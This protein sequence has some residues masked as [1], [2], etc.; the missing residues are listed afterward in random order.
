MT[1]NNTVN[2][3]GHKN[4]DTDSICSAIAYT[5]LKNQ[6]DD[7]NVYV[8]SRAGK[9]SP[10]TRFVLDKFNI[11]AP[12]L[13]EDVRARVRDMEI[14]ALKGI[15]ESDSMKKAWEY[16]HEM[17]AVSL[18][19]ITE[20]NKLSGLL[21]M[22]DITQSYM[23]VYD[24]KIIGEAKTP[25]KNIIETINGKMVV[26]DEKDSVCGGKVLIGAQNPDVMRR[27]IEKGDIV[28]VGNRSESQLCAIEAGADCIIISGGTHATDSIKMIAEKSSVKIIESDFDT[29]TL[30]RLMNQSI[31][32]GHFMN[33]GT[34]TTFSTD[35]FLDD[36][37]DVMSEK[38][39][40][41]F[42]V[43]DEKG[44]YAGM[45][46]R[47]NLLTAKKR[48]LILVDHNEKSQAVSGFET[49]EI[50][51][52][53]DH[54]RIGNIETSSPIFFRNMA[55]GCT[56]TILYGMFLENGIDIPQNIAG[57][58][59]S[60]ILS[61]TLAFRSPTCTAADRTRAT[62]LREIAHIDNIDDYASEMFEAGSNLS[63]ATPDEIFFMDF[64]KFASNSVDFGVGQISSMSKEGL[65]AAKD[66]L[67]PEMDR[68]LS[69]QNC[70]MMFFM[71]TNI[72]TE[73]SEIIFCG[74]DAL[75]T[76]KL[77]FVDTRSKADEESFEC[78]GV[79][80]RKKQMIPRLMNAI[81]QL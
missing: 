56:A 43:I 69:E 76:M 46:S 19:V 36:V 40:R 58:L 25:Y 1:N 4:P 14:T 32:V 75:R 6:L 59:L 8:A 42:P 12:I 62:K 74:R 34:L 80:S 31:P 28:I 66:K 13:V 30:A 23:E 47:H 33:R 70:D 9:V 41:N 38:R 65:K 7:G 35:D 79:V 5:Y 81:S 27:Y 48:K 60:A 10:E 16:M 24:S 26:G 45:V 57:L 29:Y 73:S 71:L 22:G 44:R 64:K 21:T 77:A 54:H 52:I 63:Q 49:A 68:F 53:V 18:A 78:P 61:D 72:M 3:I 37:K 39:Y 17:K 15:S 55:V 20:K 50:L 67:V 2:V 51:E 11:E